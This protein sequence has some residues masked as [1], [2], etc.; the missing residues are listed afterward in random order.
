MYIYVVIESN[1]ADYAEDYCEEIGGVYSSLEIAKSHKNRYEETIS[2]IEQW[3]LN[4]VC[5]NGDVLCEE[6]NEDE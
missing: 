6:E 2:R 5:V 3:E 4:G 1:K